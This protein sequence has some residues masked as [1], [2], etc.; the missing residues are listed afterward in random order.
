MPKLSVLV[1]DDDATNR[2]VAEII[3]QASGYAVSLASDGAEAVA[4]IVDGG[5][6]FDVILMDVNMP[7]MDGFTATRHLRGCEAGKGATI[8]FVTGSLVDGAEQR[9][10]DVGGDRY[11]KKPLKRKEL[12]TV[13]RNTLV[14]KGVVDAD[15]LPEP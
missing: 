12:L 15:E 4:M 9:C 8:I 1:V 3:L 14:A 10:L 7:A 11:F 2:E 13:I 6:R 5:R